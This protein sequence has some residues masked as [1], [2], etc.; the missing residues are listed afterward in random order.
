MGTT[1]GI[2]FPV[3]SAN[4]VLTD[5]LRQGAQR[6]LT[7]CAERHWRTLNE[8]KLLDDVIRGVQFI[9]GLRKDVA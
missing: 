5:V 9:D 3:Q 8:A 4:D 1:D 6:L 7:Q 2:R